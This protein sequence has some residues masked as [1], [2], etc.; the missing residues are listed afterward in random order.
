M[1]RPANEPKIS[2]S[3]TG[4]VGCSVM[5]PRHIMLC[6]AQF[7]GLELSCFLHDTTT[8]LDKII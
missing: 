1:G 7:E 3:G 5:C 2:V 4:A 8:I 6:I